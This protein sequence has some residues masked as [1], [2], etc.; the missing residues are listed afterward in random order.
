MNNEQFNKQSL[1]EMGYTGI[2]FIISAP[3]GS[4]KTTLC[5]KAIDYFPDLRDSISYTTRPPRKGER[6]GIEYHFVSKE[7]F[8]HKIKEGEF[9]EWAEVHENMYGTSLNDI[10]TLLKK[11]VDI[12]LDID[13]QGA[14]K[15]KEKSNIHKLQ[16]AV[17]IFIFPPSIQ[18]CEQRIKNRGKDSFEAIAKRLENARNEIK[19]AIWYDYVII[20]DNLEDA[21]E[22]FKSIIIAEKNKTERMIKEI[23]K[24]YGGI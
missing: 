18:A 14:R 3:S 9:I 6:D 20:N 8:Q 2:P 10:Q 11:D 4:G 17:Y 15:I 23:K 19:E 12:I 5:K 13:V 1:E 16:S 22:R 7:V 24:L 21:F